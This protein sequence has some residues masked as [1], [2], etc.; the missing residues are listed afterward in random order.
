MNILQ[1]NAET[2]DKTDTAPFFLKGGDIG[3]LL[4]HGFGGSPLEMKGLGLYL[5]S[6]GLTIYGVRLAG[7]SRHPE[8]LAETTWHDWVASAEQ[9]LQCL[10]ES[11][12]RLFIAGFSAGGTIALYLSTQHKLD[13]LITMATP[14]FLSDW[15][16]NLVPIIKHFKRYWTM[17]HSSD[18]TDQRGLTDIWVYDRLPL[19]AID[20]LRQF[21][22]ITKRK[23]PTVKIPALI[24]Q[25]IHDRQIP[26]ANAQYIYD[27]IGSAHKEL[28]WWPN[29]GHGL[30]VDSEK[31]LVWERAYA[32]ISTHQVI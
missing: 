32:F 14:V 2:T 6:N 3:C 1:E 8:N 15:R 21:L 23:L 20:S 5:A 22:T 12:H 25:G 4:I 28:V 29:S 10:Q 16:L 24:M 27:H 11:C 9:G 7:H 26:L 18:L 31:G 30:T 17:S 19:K 13:G